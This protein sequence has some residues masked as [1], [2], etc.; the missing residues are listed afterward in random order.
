MYNTAFPLIYVNI[1][2]EESD[3]RDVC[4]PQNKH[5]SYFFWVDGLSL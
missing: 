3:W 4:F 5:F 1:F 2:E